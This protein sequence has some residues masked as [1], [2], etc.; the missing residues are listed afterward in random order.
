MSEMRV[1]MFVE[2]LKIELKK[3][4]KYLRLDQMMFW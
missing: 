2:P 1:Q 3:K 4:W